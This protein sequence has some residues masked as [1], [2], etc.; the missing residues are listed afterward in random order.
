MPEAAWKPKVNPWIIAVTVTLAT[1][2]EVLDTSIANV[3]LPHIAGG[4][5]ASY[6]EATWVIT[7]YLVSN[8][9]VL[10]ISAYL[11][12]LFGRKRLYMTCVAMFGASALLC[13]LAPSLPL[14]LF[15]R[16]LQGAGGGGLGPSEQAILTDTFPEEKRSM[17]FAVYGFA[18]VMAPVLGPTV[19]G[20][21][22]EN[23]SWRWIFLINIP[24]AILSLILT[25]KLIE[26]P[27]RI[28]EEVRKSKEGDFRIDYLGFG[29]TA[30]TFGALEFVLDK[31]Q[32]DDWLSSSF[33][34]SAVVV[35]V[36][37]LIA[38]IVWELHLARA[39]KRPILDLRLFKNRTFAV[40]FVMMFVVGL[41]LYATSN[42][43]PNLLQNL[44][45]YTAELAGFVMSFGGIATLISMPIVGILGSKMD[46][47]YL[48]G[49][50]FALTGCTI[51]YLTNM[52]LQMSF[53]YASG[54]RFIQM[55]GV[56]FLFVPVSTLAY[57]GTTP[58]QSNDVSGMTNLA[59][60]VG[61]SC[62]TALVTTM[63][64]RKQQV[65][66]TYLDSHAKNSNPFYLAKI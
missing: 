9:V 22:T 39:N 11:T 42:L 8:A 56:A 51:L 48:A 61:G 35:S 17:A 28:Q 12:A 23:Y 52:D 46:N 59:R 45:G 27:P 55:L 15:F 31:G 30:L 66:Q 47:R 65:H 49:F 16:V 10:P 64:S 34:T 24:I 25:H 50:G 2:M 57:T 37:A 1:F 20:W 62:G 40:S 5:G 38:L 19:G 29:L 21:I 43:L 14:L 44:M 33:I 32:E 7:C 4:L 6:D 18:V 53:Q 36:F 63:L 54:I 13:G 41:A 26:D 58:A 3:A 60:N